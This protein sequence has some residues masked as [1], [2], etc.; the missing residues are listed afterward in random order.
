MC[1]EH[2]RLAR[3]LKNA[4][5]MIDTLEDI[6]RG[7]TDAIIERDKK[8]DG[9]R[10]EN[11]RL[12]RAGEAAQLI[13]R[14]LALLGAI[15]AGNGAPTVVDE[16]A[17]VR[18]VLARVPAG[19]S[20]A[21]VQVTPP[22]KLRADFQREEVERIMAE[23]AA[24]GALSRRIVRF[25]EG[26][27]GAR[28]TQK[29]AAERLGRSTSGGS[30]QTFSDAVKELAGVGWIDVHPKNGIAGGVR[31]KITRD[32][33]VYQATDTDIEATYQRVLYELATEAAA[34]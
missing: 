29:V 15:Q 34:A 17:I 30:M 27:E 19:G 25:L 18:K 20:G 21:V 32:L 16:E 10:A 14:G 6:R 23:V 26:L 11:E 28:L 9:L 22:E 24:M 33:E 1:Q 13:A 7:N 12:C 8:I 31:Q 4:R 3:E 2:E 5:E